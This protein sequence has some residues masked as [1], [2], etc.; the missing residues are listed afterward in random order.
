M[1]LLIQNEIDMVS[2]PDEAPDH[3]VLDFSFTDEQLSLLT[4]NQYLLRFK[5]WINSH[6]TDIKRV[7]VRNLSIPLMKFDWLSGMS[8]QSEL[9]ISM[10]CSEEIL[11]HIAFHLQDVKKLSMTDIHLRSIIPLLERVDRCIDI[12][13]HEYCSQYEIDRYQTEVCNDKGIVT[14]MMYRKVINIAEI[15]ILGLSTYRFMQYIKDLRYQMDN[16]QYT[17][18]SHEYVPKQVSLLEYL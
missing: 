18:V 11:T 13:G 16:L 5:E 12:L 9:I 6:I 15:E 10:I 17:T 3:L 2:L 1:T 7:E 8:S 14:G 4:E